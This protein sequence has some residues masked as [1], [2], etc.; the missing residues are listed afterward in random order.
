[1][2][3]IPGLSPFIFCPIFCLA[4]TLIFDLLRSPLY[5]LCFGLFGIKASL[6]R[7]EK[8]KKLQRFSDSD[9]AA[10]VDS[11]RSVSGFCL[12]N[13]YALVSW[14]SKKQNTVSRSSAE[15]EYMAL[16]SFSCEVVWILQISHPSL[17]SLYCDSKIA[18]SLAANPAHR[19]WTNMWRLTATLLENRLLRASFRCF[20]FL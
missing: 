16:A 12:F 9:W 6:F 19:A 20:M 8:K 7:K 17:A 15:A 10:C 14:G 4:R 2:G 5:L 11:R 3:I 18:L 1:M 13:G